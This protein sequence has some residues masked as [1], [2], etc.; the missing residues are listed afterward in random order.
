MIVKTPSIIGGAP[1]IEGTRVGVH[2]VI[3]YLNAYGG[4]VTQVKDEALPHIAPDGI[5]AAIAYYNEHT[6]E[7]DAIIRQNREAHAVGLA[8][9]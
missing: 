6:E 4:N 1:R 3:G 7:I 9:S 8:G 5:D 2:H